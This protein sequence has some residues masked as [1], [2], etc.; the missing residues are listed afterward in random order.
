MLWLLSVSCGPSPCLHHCCLTVLAWKKSLRLKENARK[1]AI[2][3]SVTTLGE[4]HYP[5][6]AFTHW[7]SLSL[8][9]PAGL[10][11]G[12]SKR[13]SQLPICPT[14]PA[15]ADKTP[16]SPPTWKRFNLIDFKRKTY[17]RDYCWTFLWSFPL[18]TVTSQ[19][20]LMFQ[21]QLYYK[22]EKTSIQNSSSVDDAW[23]WVMTYFCLSFKH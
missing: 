18:L 10:T 11:M 13:T 5:V 22:R 3:N 7:L 14:F 23:W 12:I 9:F 6:P 1:C 21:K 20:L 15:E 16:R 19:W 8:P 17:E 2:I 4:K